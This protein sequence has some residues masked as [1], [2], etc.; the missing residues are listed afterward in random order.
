MPESKTHPAHIAISDYSYDL[1]EEKI[2]LYPLKDRD[3]SK[4]LIYK[5]G[6]ITH[7]IFKTL[8]TH[9]NEDYFLV[10]NETKVIRARLHFKTEKGQDIEIFCLEPTEGSGDMAVQLGRE[11]NSRWNCMVGNLSRWKDNSLALEFNGL[12]LS[13]TIYARRTNHIE[14]DFSWKPENLSMA[15]VLRQLGHM[16]IPP[17]LKRSDE[18]SDQQNYQTV[19]SKIEG[20]VAAPTA[21][22]HFT[23]DVLEHLKKK[24]IDSVHLCLHVGAGTFKPVKAETIEGHEMH[25]EWMDISLDALQ[26]IHDKLQNKIIAVG[27]TSLRCLESLYWMGIKVLDKP[28]SQLHEMEVGQWEPYGQGQAIPPAT[29]AIAALIVWMKKNAMERVLCQT[30]ILLAPPY[31]TKVASGIITN[32]HQPKSTLLLLVA[33]LIGDDWRKVYAY[34]FTN[35]FRFLSYGDSSL[36]LK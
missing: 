22:L 23:P 36:L 34:A 30:S 25:P 17:Y 20:S 4:L 15:E 1:P 26:K 8:P 19:Y 13:A 27:T 3:Q 9:L 33:A 12:K 35:N 29:E 32:F 18:L 14:V 24:N 5:A 10:F 31:I 6:K 2:A 11:R 21:G 16:P 28:E 7:D